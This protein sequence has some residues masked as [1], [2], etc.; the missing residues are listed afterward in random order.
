MRARLALMASGQRCELREV[1]LRDKPPAL[2]KASPKGTVPV[3][4]TPDGSVLEESLDIMLWA[5]ARHDP[6]QWLTPEHGSLAAMLQLIAQCDGEFKFHLDR[7]KYPERYRNADVQS[8][9]AAGAMFLGRLERD[10]RAGGYLFGDRIAL[11]DMA[12]APFVRQFAQVDPD[13][14][15]AQPWPG[16]QP[17]LASFVESELYGAVMEKYPQWQPGTTGVIFP[18]G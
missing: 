3:L 9:R 4:V 8:H 17:W 14:F 11:A 12:I 2:L 5:L 16:L 1:I 15:S 7:Y 10:L 6:E 13:W 18:A